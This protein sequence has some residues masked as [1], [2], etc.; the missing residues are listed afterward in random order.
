MI[1]IVKMEKM[2]VIFETKTEK[3]E[4]KQKKKLKIRK[5]DKEEKPLKN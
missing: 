2:E 3:A 5:N 4:T 1:L